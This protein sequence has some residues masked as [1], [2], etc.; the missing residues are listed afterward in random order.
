VVAK[1]LASKSY[2]GRADV[3]RDLVVNAQRLIGKGR[4]KSDFFGCLLALFTPPKYRRIK[5][6]Y[7]AALASAASALGPASISAKFQKL[8]G[9][10]RVEMSLWQKNDEEPA[11]AA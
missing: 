1:F 4:A 5:S 6:E 11:C 2:S 10:G 3:T 9:C 7:Q 8:A